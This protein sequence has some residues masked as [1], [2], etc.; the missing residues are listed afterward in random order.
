MAQY[1]DL[2]GLQHYTDKLKDGTLVVGKANE[3]E[4]ANKAPWSG[5]ENKPEEFKPEA[6]QQ[7]ADTIDAMTGYQKPSTAG[8]ILP[9]DSLNQAVGKLEKKVEDAV[10]GSGEMNVV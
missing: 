1:L 2:A 5:I 10:A 7:G 9:T 3:A 4:S 8:A 6:H